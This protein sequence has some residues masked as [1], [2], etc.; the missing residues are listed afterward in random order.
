MVTVLTV[1]GPPY[2][3]YWNTF[4][5]GSHLRDFLDEVSSLAPM[6]SN[7]SSVNKVCLLCDFLS[8]NGP[9][10]SAYWP[11]NVYFVC[12]ELVLLETSIELSKYFLAESYLKQGCN[13]HTH[14]STVYLTWATLHSTEWLTEKFINTYKCDDWW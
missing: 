12:L 1:F 11:D 2:R 6:P 4:S 5:Y 7:G 8:S 13:K 3:C 14:C 9:V 10:F